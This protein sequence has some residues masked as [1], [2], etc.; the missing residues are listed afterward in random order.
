MPA[1]ATAAAQPDTS[2]AASEVACISSIPGSPTRLAARV[3]PVVDEAFAECHQLSQ[4]E[5]CDFLAMEVAQVLT[6][7][8]DRAGCGRP[9]PDVA[10]IIDQALDNGLSQQACI[11]DYQQATVAATDGS[12]CHAAIMKG[13]QPTLATALARALAKC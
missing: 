11:A 4:N 12:A 10:V 8:A 1:A 3:S 2:A 6:I 7:A 9:D 5:T 13:V